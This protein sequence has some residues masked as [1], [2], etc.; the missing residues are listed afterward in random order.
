GLA[1]TYA[2]GAGEAELRLLAD[3]A[4]EHRPQVAQ[5][6]AFAA[7]AR[8]RAGL[9][10]PH[11]EL[12]TQVFCGAT[13]E[14]AAGISAAARPDRPAR[15]A[16]PGRAGPGRRPG[17]RGGGAALRQG[18][19]LSGG[20]LVRARHSWLVAPAATGGRGPRPGRER[21]PDR[22][23]AEHVGRRE[24]QPGAGVQVH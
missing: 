14:E 18:V 3:R 24:R 8:V 15:R 5:A 23:P 7:D 10:V 21:V 6:S 19:R 2:G 20:V 16:R 1:A 4:G 12:A 11:T 22:P 13:P 9:V 17:L